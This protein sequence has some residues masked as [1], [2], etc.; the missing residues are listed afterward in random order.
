MGRGVWWIRVAN[1]VLIALSATAHAGGSDGESLATEKRCDGCHEID[2]P[3][4]GPPYRAIAARHARNS[5][6]MLDVL[7]QKIIDGGGGNWGVVPMVPNDHVT[8]DEAR[9]I[10]AWILSLEQGLPEYRP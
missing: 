1:L 8:F 6:V 4:L 7:A 5:D 2:R 9:A 10:A 3:L